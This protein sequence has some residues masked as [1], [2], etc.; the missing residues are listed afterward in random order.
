MNV[1]DA[2]RRATVQFAAFSATARLDAELLMAHA[3]G[4]SWGDLLLRQRDLTVPLT[5][6]DLVERRLTG[7]P[8]AY[9]VGTRDFWTISLTVTP[10]VLIPRPDSETLI[11]AAVD[12]FADRGPATVLDLGTGSGALLLAA[13]AQWP[14]ARGLGIDASPGALA[15]ARENADRL[16]MGDRADFRAGDWGDGVTG[17]FDLILINP[18][19]IACDVALAGDVLHE[20]DSAL[21]AGP[22]GL[23]DYR[24]IAPD[25]PRLLA[26]GG[27]AA[28]EIGYDQRHSVGALLTDAGLAVSC[29]IDLA[30][31]DRCLV[32]SLGE[33]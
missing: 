9:I 14:M 11:E 32:A 13:L 5:F 25:L 33:G 1:P 10:D 2:I 18:P 15:V 23:D 29:R 4:L 21:F 8:V 17:P 27:M 31:H 22:D 24:R 30:G 16:G 6:A 12:H 7:E 3:L 26:S 19:Y 28:I 20:P